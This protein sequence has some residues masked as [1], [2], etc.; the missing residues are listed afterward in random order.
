M[1][2]S[3]MPNVLQ[4]IESFFRDTKLVH[5]H[6]FLRY[7]RRS[8]P[9]SIRFMQSLDLDGTSVLDIGANRGIYCYFLSRGVGTSGTV[10]AFEPQAECIVTIKRVMKM[11]KL[12]NID[13]RNC[14]LSDKNTTATLYR[15][16][17]EHG[18]AS[19]QFY[20]SDHTPG[21]E[22]ETPV[23]TLD[24]IGDTLPRPV[25]FI[26][27]DIECHEAAMLRG[28]KEI[29]AEDKPIILI[30][31]HEDQMPEV[32][33][34]LTSYG[35]TGSFHVGKETHPVSEY[36]KIPCPKGRGHRNYVFEFK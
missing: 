14:G 22:I 17:P 4:R 28:A 34:I 35:Y 31:I 2:N 1:Y 21:Q 5:A 32:N 13:I 24:S 12:K 10:T 33:A 16:K 6:R 7:K 27:C 3:H 15:G 29:L 11:F 9:E 23:V 25:R 36:A 20:S 30:E 19:L 8:E 18:G 26:K